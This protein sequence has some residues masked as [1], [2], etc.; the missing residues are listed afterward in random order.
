MDT[1]V[2]ILEVLG[3]FVLWRISCGAPHR[4]ERRADGSLPI[5]ARQGECIVLEPT[6]CMHAGGRGVDMLL[7]GRPTA[8]DAITGKRASEES[9]PEMSESGR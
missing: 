9:F 6:V 4:L 5:D 7:N 8:V 1:H 3:A 2:N